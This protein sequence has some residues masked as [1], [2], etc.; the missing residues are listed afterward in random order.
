MLRG[1]QR[2]VTLLRSE[3]D[4]LADR[5]FR[6]GL[7]RSDEQQ[8]SILGLSGIEIGQGHC[9]PGQGPRLVEDGYVDFMR[10]LEDLGVLE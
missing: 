4:R 3:C 9:P 8:E 7:D 10:T 6:S 5:M 2:D 1:D